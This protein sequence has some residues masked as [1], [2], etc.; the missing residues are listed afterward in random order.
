MNSPPS[1]APHTSSPANGPQAATQGPLSA[2]HSPADRPGF[3]PLG[4]VPAPPHTA[5]TAQELMGMEFPTPRWA[6]P[7]VICEG[8]TLLAGPPKVGKSWM[9]LGLA[10]DIAA[11]RPAFGRI[12]TEPGSVLY[13]ALEDTP[14]RLKSRMEIALGDRPAPAG[15]TLSIACPPM[16]S[17]G[18]VQVAEWLESHPD[19][20]LVVID[21]FAKVRGTPAPGVS[22]YDADYAAMARIKRVADHYGVAVVLVHHVRKAAAED[23]LATVSGTNGL[24]GAAD[25]VLVLERAR[26]QADGVLHVTGRDVDETDYPL[27]FDPGAGAWSLL[28]GN[29]ADYQMR[30]TRSLVIRY[31][32]DYPGRRP[33]EIA[34]ALRLDAGTVRQTCR[35]MQ[36][37]GQLRA[38]AGGAYWAADSPGSGDT[39]DSSDIHATEPV[40]LLSLRHSDPADLGEHQ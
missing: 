19:A 1:P 9:S 24:A 35:R 29:A 2:P 13:L 22:A 17:G 25:A 40:S 33:K 11:G 5:W 7:G 4:A 27:A 10:L 30:D 21:V 3:P 20:R 26:A 39:S 16:P 18:D 28:D 12:T 15:L 6:V 23:F 31:L 32:R 37:D 14:R 34:E 38:N 36:N 8:V